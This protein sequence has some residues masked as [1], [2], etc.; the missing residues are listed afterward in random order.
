MRRMLS[1]DMEEYY[2]KNPNA[3]QQY[4][5]DL[6]YIEDPAKIEEDADDPFKELNFKSNNLPNLEEIP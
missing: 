6:G 1:I 3:L 2:R 4:L 5:K